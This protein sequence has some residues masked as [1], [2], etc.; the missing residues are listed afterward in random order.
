MYNHAIAALAMAEAYGL[1]NATVYRAPAQK[2]IDFITLAQNPY[3]GWRY[4][5]KPGDNDTSVTGWCVMALKS[6]EISGL[7]TARTGF[8]GARA[9]LER[10]TDK[11][12]GE[13]GYTGLGRVDVVV[14]GRNEKWGPHPSMTAVGLLCRIYVDQNAADP[15]LEKAARRIMKDLPVWN[16]AGHTVDSY[17]WYYATLALYL[18]K[19]GPGAWAW[20]SWNDAMKDAL[21]PHQK[22]RKAGCA[23]GSWDPDVDRWGF[24]GG[25][26]YMTAIN[27]LT[28]EVYYRYASVFGAR[29]G[30]E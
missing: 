23:D 28:L 16:E 1:T 8:D 19:D 20:K 29:K 12:T 18:Y 11:E 9:W 15:L 17:Y 5:V 25:R 4:H 27:V 10:V 3:L 30:K 26:V 2:G 24:A 22:T 13:V 7:T 21:I 14:P 6:A